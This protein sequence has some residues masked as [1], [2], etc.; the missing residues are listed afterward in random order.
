[1]ETKAQDL[2]RKRKKLR[3]WGREK[4]KKPAGDE[5]KRQFAGRKGPIA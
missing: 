2:E 4:K 3:L 1:L 5:K